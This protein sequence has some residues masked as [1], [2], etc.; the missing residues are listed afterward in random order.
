[1]IDYEFYLTVV[2]ALSRNKLVL[3]TLPDIA[4]RVGRLC[5]APSTS[6]VQLA[7]EIATD[8]ATAARLMQVANSAASGGP[9]VSNLPRAVARLGLRLTRTLVDRLVLE[10]MFVSQAPALTQR[11]RA[12]WARSVETAAIASV[13]ARNFTKLDPATAMLG[14][15]MREIG[16]LPIIRLA[17]ARNS[18][19]ANPAALEEVLQQLQARVGVHLLRSWRFPEELAEIPV[20]SSD[21]AREHDGPPDYADVVCVAAMQQRLPQEGLLARLTRARF[22]ALDKLGLPRRFD[23]LRYSESAA[24]LDGDRLLLAA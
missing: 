11:L 19:V 1:M 5:Q 10:Q 9:P 8:P 18:L 24:Q 16:V 21:E 22:P 20:N 14:G 3:P 23:L 4:L 12:S 15:L 6:L 17:E 13:L 7:Q 2:D